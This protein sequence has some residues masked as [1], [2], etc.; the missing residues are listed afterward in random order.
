MLMAR[1]QGTPADGD[2]RAYIGSL[3]NAADG[4]VDLALDPPRGGRVLVDNV[5]V[6]RLREMCLL[7]V[8]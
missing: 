6:V 5:D 8:M 1:G 4:T 3:E 2:G 7:G